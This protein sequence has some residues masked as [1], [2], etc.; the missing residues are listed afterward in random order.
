MAQVM[1]PLET[2]FHFWL[3]KFG[4]LVFSQKHTLSFTPTGVAGW[5][6]FLKM[7]FRDDEDSI[8]DTEVS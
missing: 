8:T 2:K 1:I 5:L 3:N 6:F 4:I 7:H